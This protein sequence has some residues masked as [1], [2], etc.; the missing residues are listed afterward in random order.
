M[1]YFDR[2]DKLALQLANVL[3]EIK[4]ATNGA[5]PSKVDDRPLIWLAEVTDDLHE[6]REEVRRYLKQAGVSVLPEGYG[7]DDARREAMKRDLS[8]CKLF[9]QLLS[10]IS[11]PPLP[12]VDQTR[13]RSQYEIAKN[14]GATITQWRSPDLD[15]SQVADPD[16]RSLING[17]TVRA[18][19]FED[20][21]RSVKDRAQQTPSRPTAR[22]Q[23]MVLLDSWEDDRLLAE[24]ISKELVA[25]GVIVTDPD[26]TASR[27]M[28]PSEV[29]QAL[30]DALRDCQG[31]IVVYGKSPTRWVREH[32]IESIKIA[33]SGSQESVA[34]AVYVGPPDGKPPPPVRGAR[35]D[36]FDGRTGLGEEQRR[37]LRA[38][39][40]A[41]PAVTSA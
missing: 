24:D 36:V 27:D 30:E 31:L 25:A 5:P 35:I 1:R 39:A 32:M 28:K 40:S 9:V 22:R 6:R 2:L 19:G 4:A 38:F 33:S 8:R 17:N 7:W 13:P 15:L 12:G 37:Q 23:A 20:F 34:L 29:R 10:S 14:A 16:H 41:I 11:G 26:F 3:R 18:E 21:K